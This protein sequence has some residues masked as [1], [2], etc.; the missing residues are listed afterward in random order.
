MLAVVTA[1][2]VT[3]LL[4][5]ATMVATEWGPLLSLDREVA[6]SL[7][8]FMRPF[9]EAAHLTEVWTETFGTWSMR[10]VSLL[11]AGW[12][13]LRRQISTAVWAAATV[14]LANLFGLFLKLGVDRARPEFTEPLAAGVGPSFPSGHSLM[15]VV[16][17]GIVL[18]TV[19][20]LLRGRIRTG[21]WVAAVLIA[22]STAV[23]RPLLAVHWVS[24]VVAGLSLGVCTVAATL[25][26][27]TFLPEAARRWDRSVHDPAANT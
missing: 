4:V 21:A 18:F 6:A 23:T 5:L 8:A 12:L 16:G 15:A 24:D 13:L 14:F 7:Y 25:L 9:P 1:V 11:A 27:W 19:L 17:M 10:V 26:L 2:A 22:L 20:P 3:P